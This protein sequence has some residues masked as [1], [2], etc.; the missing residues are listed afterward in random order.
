MLRGNQYYTLEADPAKNRIYFCIM[1]CMHSVGAIPNFEKDW[2]ATVKELTPGFTILGDLLKMKPY[3]SDVEELNIKVQEWLIKKGCRKFAQLAP[4][5]ARVQVNKFSEENGME[6]MLR[7]FH[8]T[9]TA[10][11]WL[12]KIE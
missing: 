9:K 2:E 8:Y 4:P 10:E 7:A 12:D 11:I 6:K 3:P 1:G 5:E